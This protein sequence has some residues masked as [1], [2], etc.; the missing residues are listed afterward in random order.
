MILLIESRK[1]PFE[2]EFFFG[3]MIS[4]VLSVFL[5]LTYVRGFDTVSSPVV[6]V[7]G[8]VE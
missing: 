2:P 7:S 1:L 5:L 8:N 4:V 3:A 6:V